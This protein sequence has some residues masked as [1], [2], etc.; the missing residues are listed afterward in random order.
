MLGQVLRCV[1]GIEVSD[2]NL[3]LE[4][5][6]SVCLGGA[7]HYLGHPQTLAMMQSEYI[8]PTIA[9]RTSPK[10]WEEQQKPDLIANAIARKNAIL[11]AEKPPLI[12]PALDAAIRETFTIHLNR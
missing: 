6:K 12:D 10:E 2:D 9:D 7:G 3:N 8:Y 1:R 11:A 4:P 5:M